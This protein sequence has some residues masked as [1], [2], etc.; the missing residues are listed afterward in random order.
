MTRA[1]KADPCFVVV[2]LSSID[3]Y[4]SYAGRDAAEAIAAEIAD[5]AREASCV[6]VIDQGWNER[7]ARELLRAL[8]AVAEP[9]LFKHDEDTDGWDGFEREFP[10]LLRR[11]RVRDVVLGGF[12][13]EGCVSRVKD[14]LEAARFNVKIDEY[15]SGSDEVC[16]EGFEADRR[17][18]LR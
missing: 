14:I 5:A 13:R 18:S 11:L 8:D 17:T 4:A 2:H 9:L 1:R 10:A 7:H 16:D 6:I 15:A 3:S 12:W